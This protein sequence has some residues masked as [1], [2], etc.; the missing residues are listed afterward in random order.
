MA[1][2]GRAARWHCR[3]T[4]LPHLISDLSAQR[5]PTSL[6]RH[7]PPSKMDTSCGLG[8]SIHRCWRRIIVD[9]SSG[10]TSRWVDL[11]DLV[12]CRSAMKHSVKQC[13]CMYDRRGPGTLSWPRIVTRV[14]RAF[15]AEPFFLSL[16]LLACLPD[17]VPMCLSMYPSARLRVRFVRL[18]LCQCFVLCLCLCQT[19]P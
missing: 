1:G 9:P 13:S 7:G 19:S 15:A 8:P 5:L 10:S 4:H 12:Q 14:F 3:S 17:C 6:R 18:C 16:H 2:R 11:W